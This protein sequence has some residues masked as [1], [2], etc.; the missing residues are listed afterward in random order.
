MVSVIV[1]CQ[2]G[3]DGLDLLFLGGLIA[4]I[5]LPHE[6]G[7]DLN[8]SSIHML[9]VHL[10]YTNYILLHKT[11]R[12]H[13]WISQRSRPARYTQRVQTFTVLGQFSAASIVIG[14][15]VKLPI[16]SD[17]LILYIILY[18]SPISTLIYIVFS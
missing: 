11:I 17:I 13:G 3:W 6:P 5:Y 18:Y 8:P 14:E 7:P 16:T 4:V 12:F 15:K 10:R 2:A 9:Y 1:C